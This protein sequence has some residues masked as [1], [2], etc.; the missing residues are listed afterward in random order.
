MVL[1]RKRGGLYHTKDRKQ[2]GLSPPMLVSQA[3]MRCKQEPG[4][5]ASL[6]TR[7]PVDL[8]FERVKITRQIGARHDNLISLGRVKM[9]VRDIISDVS[10]REFYIF[11][12]CRDVRDNLTRQFG[13][14]DL[15]YPPL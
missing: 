10:S 3:I 5:P 6:C 12:T 2:G 15:Y 11:C 1:Y 8:P 13:A 7:V 14:G 9:R 4:V